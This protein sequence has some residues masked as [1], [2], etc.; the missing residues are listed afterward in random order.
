MELVQD[1]EIDARL[2]RRL[3]PAQGR[4]LF[5][6]AAIL[7]APAATARIHGSSRVTSLFRELDLIALEVGVGVSDAGQGRVRWVAQADRLWHVEE[8]VFELVRQ[9]DSEARG[10]WSASL[11]VLGLVALEMVR[12]ETHRREVVARI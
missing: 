7:F 4:H 2:M 12:G 6:S 8:P 3:E 1:V 10:E 5:D 11:A 9:S